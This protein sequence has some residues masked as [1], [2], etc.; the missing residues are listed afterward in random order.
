VQLD[1]V[2]RD[3]QAEAEAA[4]RPV[5]RLLALDEALEDVRQE[6]RRDAGAVVDDR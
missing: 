6:R 1:E 3:R 4:A 2:L 5:Q